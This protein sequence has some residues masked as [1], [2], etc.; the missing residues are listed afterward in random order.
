MRNRFRFST[1][2]IQSRLNI[3]SSVNTMSSSHIIT[4]IGF[5]TLPQVDLLLV[6]HFHNDH[7]AAVPYFLRKTGFKSV[8]PPLQNEK[9]FWCI[10]CAFSLAAI[11][12]RHLVNTRDRQGQDIYDISHPGNLQAH[13]VRLQECE[14]PLSHPSTCCPPL[15]N[16]QFNPLSLLWGQISS[17][18]DD[19]GTIKL[20]TDQ[21]I[22]AGG[23]PPLS[24]SL[25][26]HDAA[27]LRSMQPRSAA[28]CRLV[29][30]ARAGVVPGGG[31][32][33]VCGCG[34]LRACLRAR[35]Y[36]CVRARERVLCC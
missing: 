31:G 5:D 12:W 15:P 30:C 20:Y 9:Y 6:T 14:R 24:R 27:R 2:A 33:S 36:V 1:T 21:D 35:L 16:P 25:P 13:L 22:Q 23:R 34:C 17:I 8:R 10:A 7:A 11:L 3:Y 32:V 4:A 26:A 19:Q 29:A 18:S 28:M